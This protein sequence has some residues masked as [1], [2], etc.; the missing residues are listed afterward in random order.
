MTE[1][2]RSWD[3]ALLGESARAFYAFT[4]YRDLPVS[5]RSLEKVQQKYDR[6]TSYR[7]QLAKWS[8]RF[9]WVERVT[10]YD[11]FIDA[12]K[13]EAAREAIIE[14]A[15]RQAQIG[16]D[17]QA[18]GMAVFIDD[19]GQLK[20]LTKRLRPQDA[21]RAIEVGAR[22]ER[23]ARGEPAEIIKGDFTIRPA[24]ELTD[25]ELA[26]IIQRERLEEE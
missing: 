13:R 23:T 15:V 11:A 17:L 4:L 6:S 3:C 12:V 1:D 18:A 7:R 19:K 5:E 8:S 25:D 16:I 20:P 26:E 10:A 24:K 2:N 14:M 22:T 9:A 21:I